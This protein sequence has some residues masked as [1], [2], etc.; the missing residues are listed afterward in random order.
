L[1]DDVRSKEGAVALRIARA[2]HSCGYNAAHVNDEVAQ[3]EIL[4][5]LRDIQPEEEICIY[6][7]SH[8]NLESEH[9][10]GRGGLDNELQC[11]E[12]TL[13]NKWGII[14]PAECDCKDPVWQNLHHKMKNLLIEVDMLAGEGSTEQALQAGDKFLE[15]QKRVNVDSLLDFQKFIHKNFY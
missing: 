3:V 14:C 7:I 13:R 1:I 5:A 8:A 6:Y 12:Q 11:I 10:A 2:N 9:S 15:I 4:Y